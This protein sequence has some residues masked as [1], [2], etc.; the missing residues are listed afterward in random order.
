[1]AA[2]AYVVGSVTLNKWYHFE[3]RA[4]STASATYQ[5]KLRYNTEE[6]DALDTGT[7]TALTSWERY[8]Y[9]FK[10]AYTDADFRIML[11]SVNELAMLFDNVVFKEVLLEGAVD[12]T[13]DYFEDDRSSDWIRLN[14]QGVIY[15][16]ITANDF[17]FKLRATDYRATG[18]NLDYLK[19]RYKLVDKR[20]KRGL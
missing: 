18:F 5:V 12:Y 16:L 3:C 14:E 2:L 11:Y 7:R 20:S 10:A 8:S 15:P 13:Y 1:M 19:P 4:K 9:C 6:V 17:K